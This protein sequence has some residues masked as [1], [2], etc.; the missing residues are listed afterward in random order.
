M[1]TRTDA[2]IGVKESGEFDNKR[3]CK[4]DRGIQR[5]SNEVA[6]YLCLEYM[7]SSS[8][9]ENDEFEEKENIQRISEIQGNS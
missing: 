5:V 4:R 9:R 1:Q 2:K 8:R 6:Q 7:Q 3:E